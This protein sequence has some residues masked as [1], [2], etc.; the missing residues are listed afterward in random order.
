L[1]AFTCARYASTPAR[2]G[3]PMS[4]TAS[5]CGTSAPRK[6]VSLRMPGLFAT[7]DS[8]PPPPPAQADVAAR[9]NA[10]RRAA[11]AERIGERQ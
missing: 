6:I 4:A 7:A 11:P 5:L 3:F 2:I 8:P 9:H 1:S 10:S